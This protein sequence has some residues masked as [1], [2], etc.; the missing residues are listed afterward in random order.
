M[1]YITQFG[2][3]LYT[4]PEFLLNNNWV[5]VSWGNDVCPRFENEELRLAVWVDADDQ[6]NREYDDWKKFNVVEL[7]VNKHDGNTLGETP[8]FD[9]EDADALD[10]WLTLYEAKQSLEDSIAVMNTTDGFHDIKDELVT[11]LARMN[12]AMSSLK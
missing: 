3:C 6:A 12:E 9:T 8:L 10:K 11:T 1:S 4:I 5:D 7:I 2:D